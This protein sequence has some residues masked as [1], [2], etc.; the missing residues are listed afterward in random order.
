MSYGFVILKSSD[1]PDNWKCA[2]CLESDQEGPVIAHVRYT[3]EA[4][5]YTI[6][7]NEGEKHPFHRKCFLEAIAGAN[8]RCPTC[9]EDLYD[10][11]TFYSSK[12]VEEQTEADGTSFA[13]GPLE[14]PFFPCP[15]PVKEL[16]PFNPVKELLPFEG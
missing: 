12:S 6:Y 14:V 9:Q 8:H 2:I 5:T 13:K 15:C 11:E 1:I 4:S 16:P 10:L 7:S 3:E